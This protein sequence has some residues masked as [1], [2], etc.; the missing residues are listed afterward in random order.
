MIVHAFSFICIKH[1]P[2][3]IP[4]KVTV[5]FKFTQVFNHSILKPS[6]LSDINASYIDNFIILAIQSANPII[7]WLNTISN[8]ASIDSSFKG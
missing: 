2:C 5:T 8:V 1:S 7:G 6:V 4:L 3:L